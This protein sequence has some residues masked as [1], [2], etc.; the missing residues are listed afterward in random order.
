MT[1]EEAY[2]ELRFRDAFQQTKGDSFQNLFEKV[3]GLAFKE[4]FM[5]CRP[6]G[7]DGD[8]KNDGFLKSKRCLFQVYAPNEMSKAESISKITRDFAGALVHWRNHFDEWIFVHNAIAGL[9]PHVHEVILEL[10]KKNADVRLKPW[11]LEELLAVFRTV[12]RQDLESWFGSAPIS[13]QTKARL[14]FKDLQVVL[15]RIGAGPAPVSGAVKDVP[16]GKLAANALSDAV[17]T[18]LRA[19]MVK[20]PLVADFFVQWHDEAFGE[21]IAQ[22]F[23]AKYRELKDQHGPDVIFAELRRW[24]G[25]TDHGLPEHELATLAVL[26][27]F[28]DS[29]DIFEE[30]RPTP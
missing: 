8:R 6:W 14:G 30:P 19:G 13:E 15:E 17:A 28:F 1:L 16:A 25:G 7:Q 22:A 29:C 11:G 26:A 3:M 20:A 10:E 21:R 9:P 5:A 4:D 18:L 27:Y 23:R 2:F 12:G 24:A